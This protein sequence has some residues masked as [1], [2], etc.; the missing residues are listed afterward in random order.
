[1]S[2]GP[3]SHLG[4]F[5]GGEHFN[6]RRHFDVGKH[7]R[8]INVVVIAPSELG[9]VSRSLQCCH[10]AYGMSSRNCDVPGGLRGH[11]EEA[12][13]NPALLAVTD[14]AHRALVAGIRDHLIYSFAAQILKSMPWEV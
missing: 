5:R 8:A 7:V 13:V 11:T 4:F 12:I 1:V 14:L 9:G 6:S 10:C 3:E 2:H